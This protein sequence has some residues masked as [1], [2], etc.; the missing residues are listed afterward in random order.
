[1][2]KESVSLGQLQQD[3]ERT[4]SALKSKARA[5]ERAKDDLTKAESEY[6]NAQKALKAG[7]ETV[8]AM[9]KVLV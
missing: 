2:K 3:V 7:V 5:F 8:S 1:M 6:V 9:T 4:S